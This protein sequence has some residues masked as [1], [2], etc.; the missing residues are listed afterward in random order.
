MTIRVCDSLSCAMAG[1]ETLIETLKEKA[2]KKV[3]ILHAP[4]MGL[5]DVAPAAAVGKN[6]VGNAPQGHFS[7]RQSGARQTGEASTNRSP[8]TRR[9]A[10]TRC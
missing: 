9:R 7:P 5:C 2:S 3:R 8:S 4:C 10:A 6:Y 1:A